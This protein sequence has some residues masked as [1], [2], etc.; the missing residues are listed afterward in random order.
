M[1]PDP[2]DALAAL[3]RALTSDLDA[4]AFSGAVLDA[5]GLLV[6]AG[7]DVPDPVEVFAGADQWADDP[8]AMEAEVR[9]IVAANVEAFKI[10]R[11]GMAN[12]Q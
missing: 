6:N 12:P 10:V 4:R 5:W 2:M 11:E 8:A 1:A 7:L 9:R 3:Y